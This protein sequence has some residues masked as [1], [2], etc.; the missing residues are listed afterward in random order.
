MRIR[1]FP[2]SF[3]TRLLGPDGEAVEAAVGERRPQH[4]PVPVLA[5]GGD[6]LELEFEQELLRDHLGAVPAQRPHVSGDIVA[7]KVEPVQL[8][9]PAAPVDAAAGQRIH[10]VGGVLLRVAVLDDRLLE[11]ASGARLELMPSLAHAP[12]VVPALPD[13]VDLL[14]LVL[15]DVA[16]PQ[17]ARLPVEVIAPGV[18]PSR[19]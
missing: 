4:V 13:D 19:R 16:R 11:G 8:P 7:V 18:P 17:V 12:A 6:L 14:P 15:A 2:L 1:A 9:E 10:A 5:E 3:F